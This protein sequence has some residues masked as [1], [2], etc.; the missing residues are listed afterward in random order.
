MVLGVG[1]LRVEIATSLWCDRDG[2]GAGPSIAIPFFGLDDCIFLKPLET[3][4]N[5]LCFIDDQI[6]IHNH[7]RKSDSICDVPLC[8]C[9][10]LVDRAPRRI[11][12]ASAR[13]SRS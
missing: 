4:R 11:L 3:L 13:N 1:A 5:A 9:R 7:F 6:M 2:M 8:G 12:R 10:L